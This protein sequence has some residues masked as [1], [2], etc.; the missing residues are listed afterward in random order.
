MTE[1]KKRNIGKTILKIG[2]WTVGSIVGL[3]FILVL[4]IQLPS[5][6]NYLTDRATGYL[7]KKLKTQVEI[8]EI[9]VAFPKSILL[10]DICLK[11]QKKDTLLYAHRLA[12]D[13]GF[14]GFFAKK[15]DIAR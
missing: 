13:I 2:A 5:V 8:G 14:F 3:L 10:K 4:L 9:N 6:Q 7:E 15:I 11:D 12:V 1:T